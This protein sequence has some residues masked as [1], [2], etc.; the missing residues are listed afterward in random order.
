MLPIIP[1]VPPLDQEL[2]P[3]IW[4]DG[5]SEEEWR[6]LES[7]MAVRVKALGNRLIATEL[8]RLWNGVARESRLAKAAHALEAVGAQVLWR[9]LIG[10][11][12]AHRVTAAVRD[13]LPLVH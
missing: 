11:W 8:P 7:F 12:V 6:T 1:L 9:A 13:H 10:P 4:P 3:P 5:I 2:P